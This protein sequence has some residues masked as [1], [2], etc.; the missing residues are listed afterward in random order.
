VG[1]DPIP[2]SRHALKCLREIKANPAPMSSATCG[3]VRMLLQEGLIEVVEVPSP[4]PA[5]NGKKIKRL[6]ITAAGLY[7]LKHGNAAPR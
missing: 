3:A 4:F 2:L 7:G 6:A 5:D 1:H